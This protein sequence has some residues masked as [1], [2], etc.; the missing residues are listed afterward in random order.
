[1][2]PKDVQVLISGTHDYVTLHGF[3]SVKDIGVRRSWIIRVSSLSPPKGPYKTGQEHQDRED[4]GIAAE[5]REE[6]RCY[7]ADFEDGR[8]CHEPRMWTASKS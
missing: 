8:R 7:D 1:M 4:V 3:D 6:R 5:V 2:S